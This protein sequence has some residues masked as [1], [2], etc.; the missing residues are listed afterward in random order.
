MFEVLIATWIL[1][2]LAVVFVFDVAF[3]QGKGK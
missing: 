3:T 1:I 2:G